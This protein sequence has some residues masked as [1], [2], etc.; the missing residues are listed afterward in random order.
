[1]RRGQ[2]DWLTRA[3]QLAVRAAA[4]LEHEPEL[5]DSLY[6]GQVGVAVLAA[7]L[8]RQLLITAAIIAVFRRSPRA[9]A[10]VAFRDGAADTTLRGGDTLILSGDPRCRSLC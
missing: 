9:D 8:A 6:K 4:S 5:A 2:R 1:M 7:E 10:E 3:C